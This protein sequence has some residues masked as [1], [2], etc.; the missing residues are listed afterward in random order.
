MTSPRAHTLRG[1]AIEWLK[2]DDDIDDM[3]GADGDVIPVAIVKES[4]ADPRISVGAS[5]NGSDRN[6]QLEE[7]SFEVRVIVDGTVGTAET[8][9]VFALEELKA[10]VA[11]VL[12]TSRDGWGAEGVTADE[13]VAKNEA[14]NR[15]LGVTQFAFE[16]TD[17]ADAFR[18]N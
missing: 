12:T 4:D 2:T 10:R 11:D 8:E 1:K 13:E 17:P 14:T 5:M 15:Y 9:T 6:N 3:L 18:D 7:K 16:R